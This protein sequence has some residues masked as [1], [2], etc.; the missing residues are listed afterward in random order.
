[1][2]TT[3]HT[4]SNQPEDFACKI[5]RDHHEALFLYGVGLC[6]RFRMDLSLADDILQ[7]TYLRIICDKKGLVKDGY[8]KTGI[9][10]IFTMMYRAMIGLYRKNRSIR[11]LKEMTASQLPAN[12]LVYWSEREHMEAFLVFAE[13][14]LPESEYTA[15][16][17]YVEGYV[18]REIAEQMAVSIA[19]AFRL[20]DNARDTLAKNYFDRN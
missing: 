3:S 13:K 17:L 16:E 5:H 10:Y 18:F 9:A 4:P 12:G 15:I 1:M 20:V 8:Q 7:E 14:I 6:K 19:K 2:Y 11:R